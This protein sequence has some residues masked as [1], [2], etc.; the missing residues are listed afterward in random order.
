MYHFF[1]KIAKIRTC[2]T[3]LI[4]YFYSQTSEI[5]SAVSYIPGMFILLRK[6]DNLL[7][8]LC[9]YYGI[10]RNASE[11]AKLCAYYSTK[12]F[13]IVMI[14]RRRRWEGRIGG[15]GNRQ[16]ATTIQNSSKSF[17]ARRNSFEDRRNHSK[18]SL[19]GLRPWSPIDRRRRMSVGGGLKNN[20]IQS[21]N[22]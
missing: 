18:L 2:T 7:A 11:L 13:G 6:N 22:L 4:L 17:E 15:G 21:N 16:L 1:L 10:Q 12:C 20:Q 8:K 3:S 14:C 9:A 5:M 19:P